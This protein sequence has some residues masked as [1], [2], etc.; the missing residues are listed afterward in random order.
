MN[1]NEDLF[2]G[3]TPLIKK[4]ARELRNNPTLEE[5]LIWKHLRKKAIGYKIRRQHPVSSFIVDFYCHE[6]KVAIEIDG[7]IHK[8]RN[9]FVKDLGRT[10][11]L[12]RFGIKVI[13]YTNNDVINTIDFVVEDIIKV[14]DSR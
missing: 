5:M 6:K 7:G 13:R 14:L 1:H 10:A 9:Q 11:E 4:M 12:E 2:F 3:A 8:E